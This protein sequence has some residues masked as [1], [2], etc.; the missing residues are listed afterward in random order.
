[1]KN[2]ANC[3]PKEFLIQTNKIRK[4]AAHWMDITQVMEIR[5]VLPDTDGLEPEEKAKAISAQA[6]K[7]I[8][9]MLDAAL[10]ANVD[11]T[12]ELLGMLCFVAPEE[13]NDHPVTEY[14]AAFSE[15]INCPEVV[16]FFTSL[17]QLGQMTGFG[18]ARA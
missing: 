15:I 13:A 7:N 9:D 17:M 1:M 14:L 18:A 8:S 10:E 11:E 12:V 3:S 5:K 4:Q 2:L 6:K 16:G